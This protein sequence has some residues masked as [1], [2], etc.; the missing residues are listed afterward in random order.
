[1]LKLPGH[2]VVATGFVP[3]DGKYLIHDPGRNR[4]DLSM[5]GGTF[6]GIRLYSSSLTAPSP[7]PSGLVL[8]GASPIEL[9]VIDPE[10]LRTGIDPVSGTHFEEIPNASY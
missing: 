6:E 10:G 7:V 3:S 2:F 4:W 9:L 5:Y 8:V 1:M